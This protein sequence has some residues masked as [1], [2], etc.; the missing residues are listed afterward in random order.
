M[1]RRTENN[2]TWHRLIN[3]DRGQT[4][5]ERLAAQILLSEKYESVDPSHPL[6]GRDGLKDILCQKDSMKFIAACYFPRG[7]QTFA[8]IK[9]KFSDDTKGIEK[10]NSDGIVF[11]T[12]QELR[13]AERDELS[14]C[15]ANNQYLDLYHLE[16][17]NA[18]LNSPINFGT[19]L[20]FLDI[21]M[22]KEEQLA[23]MSSKDQ[24]IHELK[25]LLTQ[26]I[27][28]QN[29]SGTQS[30]P[31]TLNIVNTEPSLKEDFKIKPLTVMPE[32]FTGYVGDGGPLHKC[33][34]CGY[35]YKV[36]GKGLSTYGGSPSQIGTRGRMHYSLVTCPK[37]GSVEQV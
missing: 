5:S 6:G 26:V 31:I 12:N 16:R 30:G 18:I 36:L 33:G 25:N 29:I 22:T 2:E 13:L 4:A 9:E 8:A 32:S 10:N 15:I 7:Q 11:I 17:L 21:E 35:S 14:Q 3:W 34:H 20:E 23:Y 24:I 27:Q 19:R 1:R 28:N 37:C